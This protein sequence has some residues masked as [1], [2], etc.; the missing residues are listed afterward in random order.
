M[1]DLLTI[2]S[3][4]L[5]PVFLAA[6][7]GYI[8]AKIT[9]LSP[10]PLSQVIFYIFSPCLIYTLL[11]DSDLSNGDI[12]RMAL[13]AVATIASVGALTFL[14]GKAFKLERRILAG[15]VLGSMIM[16]SG[17]Y[18]L[19][20]ILFAFGDEALKYASLFFAANSM[21][22]YTLGVLVASMG[23]ASFP[24]AVKSL[25]KVPGVYALILALV[26]MRTGWQTPLPLAR[27]V[28]LLGDA[29]IPAMLVLLGMQ[30]KNANLAGKGRPLA[31]ATTMRLVG[32]PI[33]GI[34][35]AP[36]FGL[37]G[38]AR[39][40]GVTESAM[41]TA[42]LTTVLAMEYDATPSLVT[43]IVFTTTI[44]SPLTITPL[45]AILGT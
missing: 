22:A 44:L 17:N 39:Q 10:R 31:L 4:N 21:T 40:A 28:N 20:V 23:K 29:S 34:I 19:P 9:N 36:I 12:L 16:N 11:T 13:F 45:L 6:G 25:A 1:T 5:L 37:S 8:L 24:T 2:F 26:M 32:G 30:L 18:G 42:V 41:P 7:A 33:L 43:T 27:T 3:N 15:T 35:L 38:A 14:V